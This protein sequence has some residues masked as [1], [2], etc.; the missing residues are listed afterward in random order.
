MR[1][2][3]KEQRRLVNQAPKRALRILK[4]GSNGYQP[5]KGALPDVT[6]QVAAYMSNLTP[7]MISAVGYV[8]R[9]EYLSFRHPPSPRAQNEPY[10]TAPVGCQGLAGTATP[11]P[12]PAE[13]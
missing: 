2:I 9:H 12:P 6:S 4:V 8:S 1:M 5:F 11:V 13:R 7:E 10:P 3:L